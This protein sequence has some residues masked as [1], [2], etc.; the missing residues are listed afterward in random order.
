MLYIACFTRHSLISIFAYRPTIR[1]M[2][3]LSEVATMHSAE[4]CNQY[5]LAYIEL[6]Y[7]NPADL[8]NIL[9]LDHAQATCNLGSQD[10]DVTSTG[11]TLKLRLQP[12]FI[13]GINMLHMRM[14]KRQCYK[15]GILE[16]HRLR[17]IFS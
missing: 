2:E 9:L 14:Y 13:N 3:N 11:E 15:G 10:S 7:V 1:S 16:M 5:A 17:L 12:I 4:E 6:S 8:L